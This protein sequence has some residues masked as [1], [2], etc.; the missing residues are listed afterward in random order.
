M[1]NITLEQ[2]PHYLCVT[3]T[4]AWQLAPMLSVIDTLVEECR[5]RD[6]RAVLLDG[7]AVQGTMPDFARYRVGERIAAVLSGIR[8]TLLVPRHTI[9]KFAENVAVNRGA[10][11]LVTADREAAIAWLRANG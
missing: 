11:F 1:L 8:I 3:L 9:N 2:M 6:C 5:Q 7:M 10:H 4:G